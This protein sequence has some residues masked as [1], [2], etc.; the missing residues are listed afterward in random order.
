MSIKMLHDMKVREGKQR[1]EG[2]DEDVGDRGGDSQDDD[3]G[4]IEDDDDHDH[5]HEDDDKDDEDG[6]EEDEE[7]KEPRPKLKHAD[8]AVGWIT[9]LSIERAAGKEML[10][11]H[12]SRLKKKTRWT[13]EFTYS[14][15]LE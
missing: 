2:E 8:Y 7:L 14:I 6:K 1:E 11:W 4:D 15:S 9:A 12:H 10:D 13:R 5:D 3:N